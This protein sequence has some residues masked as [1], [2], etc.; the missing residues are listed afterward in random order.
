MPTYPT[1]KV[2]IYPGGNP[3]DSSTWPNAVDISSYV[4]YP[5]SDGGQTISYSGGRQDEANRVDSSV[6]RLTLDNRDGRFSIHNPLG[7][8]Y[9]KLRRNTPITMGTVAFSDDFN[10][11]NGALGAGWSGGSFA[12]VSNAATVTLGTAGSITRSL[13]V[14]SESVNCDGR[15]TISASAVATGASHYAGVLTRMSSSVTGVMIRL[16]FRTDSFL[17]LRLIKYVNNVVTD[18]AVKTL[19]VGYLAN[20][21]VRLHWICDGPIVRV[22]AWNP[23]NPAVPDADEPAA[24]TLSGNPGTIFGGQSGMFSWRQGTNTN[25]S[26]AVTV[27]D[28]YVEANEFIG[29]VTQWPVDWNMTGSNSWAAIQAG[30]V[31]RR[32]QQGGGTL[33][34]PLRRQLGSYGPN[35]YWPLEDGGGAGVF[36]SAVAVGTAATFTA[37]TPAGDSSLPG[38]LVAATFSDPNA[39]IRGFTRRRQVGTYPL[40]GFSTVLFTKLAQ[41]TTG[42]TILNS[43]SG[44]GRIVLW[45]V[46]LDTGPTRFTLRGYESDG[47]LTVDTFALFANPGS[48]LDPLQW[49]AWNLYTYADGA[50]VNYSL[51]AYQVGGSGANGVVGSFASSG[52]CRVDSFV[53]GGQD[54][55]GA[56]FSHVWMGE[57]PLPLFGSG[58]EI[59]KIAG[60]YKGEPAMTRLARICTEQGVPLALEAGGGEAMGA[61]RSASY[62]D[63]VRYC[64]DADMGVLYEHG[65]GLGYRPRAARY[66]T[67][68]AFTLLRS[69][70]EL[71]D[72][73]RPLADD[74]ATRNQW[75]ITRDSGSSVT[76]VDS[77][78]IA[79]EGLYE[80]SA[81]LNVAGDNNLADN[82]TW[83]VY[84]GTRQEARWPDLTMD[85]VRNPRLA[86]L[87]RSSV[88]G[89]RLKATIGQSQILDQDPD[90]ILEGWTADLWP[91]GWK[92]RLNCSPAQPWDVGTVVTAAG[93]VGEV[94]VDS[95]D[96]T[97]DVAVPTP[98]FG[99]IQVTNTNGRNWAASTTPGW[100][101][102]NI[103]VN[104]EVMTVTNVGA[105]FSTTKQT[106]TVT[107]GVNGAARTHA[108][109]SLVIVQPQPIIGL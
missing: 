18:V 87:W 96:S 28:F 85:L 15:A 70:G 35:G 103:K 81:T 68:T 33:M 11:T 47:T 54:L 9:G 105:V 72:V 74:S 106:F 89:Q 97:I 82:A 99:T 63:N 95:D 67:A 43:W 51:D 3:A 38:A 32:L 10:R 41:A 101:A 71:A 4:R 66:S 13:A 59:Q 60:G 2:R 90:V 19:P 48:P 56:A 53:L 16:E 88:Y 75:T 45:Q 78:H 44:G 21:K 58:L 100:A 31:L 34:S 57:Y 12:V 64:E 77:A 37:V 6:L 17:D 8:Y 98:T 83:R 36:G 49:I 102:F 30:G 94:V 69:A 109:G 80:D 61:Q 22:K 42:T 23:A 5:G 92:I 27:D 7:P 107:R 108:V 73:P 104:G 62:L 93:D 65:S 86:P 84:L 29:A 20:T 1:I 55:N 14:G 50:L 25:A 40:A 79:A 52:P 26:L 46:V 91:H 39:R 24:W 76:A